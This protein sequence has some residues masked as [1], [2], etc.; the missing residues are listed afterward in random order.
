[1]SPSQRS[2][3]CLVSLVTIDAHIS[4]IGIVVIFTN[5]TRAKVWLLL[6]LCRNV[7][8]KTYEHTNIKWS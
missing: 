6:N 5:S 3:T 2:G 4:I 8:K 7:N 1:L